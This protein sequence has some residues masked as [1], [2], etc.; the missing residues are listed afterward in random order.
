VCG[1][2]AIAPSRALVLSCKASLC[3]PYRDSLKT[4][5]IMKLWDKLK[6]RSKKKSKYGL[7]EVES[8]PP[9]D[10]LPIHGNG[11]RRRQRNLPDSYERL[12][13]R[14]LRESQYFDTAPPPRREVSFDIPA[15]KYTSTENAN[16]ETLPSSTD[17]TDPATPGSI[18]VGIDFGTT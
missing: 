17:A 15:P 16:V 7:T 4:I 5:S 9:E 2:S 1:R 18:L 12:P 3:S 6:S 8:H 10:Y 11:L 13:A 14:N